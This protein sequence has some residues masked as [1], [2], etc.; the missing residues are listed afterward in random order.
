MSYLKLIS[1]KTRMH[2]VLTDS[3]SP[4]A[5]DNGAQHDHASC[6]GFNG[7]NKRC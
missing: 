1:K 5:R 6:N 2:L 4:D 3:E 7:N